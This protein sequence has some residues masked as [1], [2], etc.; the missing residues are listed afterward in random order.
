MAAAFQ[1]A[2][3]FHEGNCH[4]RTI[5]IDESFSKLDEKR[6]RRIL[7]YLTGK[8]GLQVLFAMPSVKSGPFKSICTH[9][10]VVQKIKDNNPPTGSELNTRV[11]VDSQELN[12]DAIEKLFAGYT[13]NVSKEASQSFLKLLEAEEP[14]T[15]V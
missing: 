5:I 4:L 13:Q 14:E 3:G 6:S 12:N 2:M 1:S 7:Q 10:L 11:I 15:Y 8:L 9:Q